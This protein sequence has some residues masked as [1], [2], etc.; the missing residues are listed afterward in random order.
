M[1]YSAFS[2]DV[3]KYAKR[4]KKKGVSVE[5]GKKRFKFYHL[6][7]VHSPYTFGK[8]LIEDKEMKYTVYDEAEG[9]FTILRRYFQQMKDN[10][11]YDS[12]TIIILA[13]H[14]E[15][16]YAQ[17]PLF[18]VKNAEDRHEFTVSNSKMSWEYLSDLWKN[19][20]NGVKI[21][22]LFFQDY[23]DLHSKYLDL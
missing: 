20:A 12:S 6:T 2:T 14:G 15:L 17:N 1:S 23:T 10:G 4:L 18:M 7:G 22:E 9:N 16:N 11:T 21:D 8:K 3:V 13:D 19:L 5:S